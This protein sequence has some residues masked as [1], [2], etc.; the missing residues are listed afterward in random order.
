MSSEVIE[1][2]NALEQH[3]QRVF[4]AGGLYARDRS[5]LFRFEGYDVH[6]IKTN[7]DIVKLTVEGIDEFDCVIF[8]D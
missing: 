4:S 1:I 5:G 6:W 2:L 3:C 8:R 7:P